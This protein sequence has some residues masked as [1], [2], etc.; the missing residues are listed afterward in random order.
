MSLLIDTYLDKRN[1]LIILVV[2]KQDF[3]N[4]KTLI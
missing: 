3:M 4:E 1:A 2:K